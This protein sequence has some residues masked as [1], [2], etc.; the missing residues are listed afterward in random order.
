MTAPRSPP[1]PATTTTPRSPSTA[2]WPRRSAPSAGWGP[3]P[4]S[5]RPASSPLQLD[6]LHDRAW[7]YVDGICAGAAG[8]DPAQAALPH[9][10]RTDATDPAVVELAHLADRLL[11]DGGHRTVRVEILVENLGRVNFG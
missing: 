10:E 5:C 6:D 3:G 9:A 4:A 7:V 11:P 1:P 8:L 2:R